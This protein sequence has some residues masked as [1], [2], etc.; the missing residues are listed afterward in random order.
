MTLA[1]ET[2]VET[3]G[4]EKTVLI[5]DDTYTLMFEDG[6]ESTPQ[7]LASSIEQKDLFRIYKNSP[8]P[9]ERNKA[10]KA[11]RVL[12]DRGMNL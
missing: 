4:G 5:T 12:V 11:L 3:V 6:I 1:I 7:T 9:N 10:G 2:Q 8:D